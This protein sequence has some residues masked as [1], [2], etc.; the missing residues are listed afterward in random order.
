MVES[1]SN[2]VRY[3]IGGREVHLVSSDYPLSSMFAIDLHEAPFRYIAPHNWT[4]CKTG[5][6]TLLRMETRERLSLLVKFAFLLTGRI[7]QIKSN[8]ERDLLLEFEKICISVEE[9][10]QADEIREKNIAHR[11]RELDELLDDSETAGDIEFDTPEKTNTLEAGLSGHV[12]A[13]GSKR[14]AS[15]DDENPEIIFERSLY[16]VLSENTGY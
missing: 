2:T 5:E 6:K 7:N 4:Q 16:S 1:K 12:S 11:R 3:Y 9:G 13:S 15:S 14:V 8:D 10:L